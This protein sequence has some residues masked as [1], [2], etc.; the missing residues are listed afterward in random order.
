MEKQKFVSRSQDLA[1]K[2]LSRLK[3]TT[4][5]E[6]FV[7]QSDNIFTRVTDDDTT[8]IEMLKSILK[9]WQIQNNQKG[10]GQCKSCKYFLTKSDNSYQ[11]KLTSES[12]DNQ[13]I[14]KICKEHD[15]AEQ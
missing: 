10:F 2:R 12:L 11:C 4:R 3:L 7:E 9:S 5:G 6:E 1:D 14:Q 8:Q 15:F 13:D